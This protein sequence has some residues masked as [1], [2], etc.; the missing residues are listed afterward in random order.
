M[1]RGADLNA[2]PVCQARQ[3]ACRNMGVC[4]TAPERR[5]TVVQNNIRVLQSDLRTVNYSFEVKRPDRLQ[6][7]IYRTQ[8]CPLA[9]GYPVTAG[10]KNIPHRLENQEWMT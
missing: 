2:T 1:L 6:R 8:L 10:R 3:H 4:D 7:A 5:H 9:A